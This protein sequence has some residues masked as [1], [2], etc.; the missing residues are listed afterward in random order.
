MPGNTEMTEEGYIQ[1]DIHGVLFSGSIK[2][3]P[4][5]RESISTASLGLLS[6]IGVHQ[7]K[8]SGRQKLFILGDKSVSL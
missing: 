5:S 1:P 4:H 8:H 6:K 3:S 2:K 7:T